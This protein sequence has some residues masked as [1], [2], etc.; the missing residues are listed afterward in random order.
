LLVKLGGCLLVLLSWFVGLASGAYGQAQVQQPRESPCGEEALRLLVCP[1]PTAP[2]GVVLFHL[3][4]T[5]G[6]EP[7][8]A[9]LSYDAPTDTDRLLIF[10]C[11]AGR[12]E[13]AFA[14]EAP[15]SERWDNLESFPSNG[16]VPGVVIWGGEDYGRTHL[17]IV[18]YTGSYTYLPSGKRV[19]NKGTFKVAFEGDEARLVDLDLDGIPEVVANMDSPTPEVWTLVPEKY[20]KVGTFQVDRLRPEY[21]RRRIEAVKKRLG[22]PTKHRGRV[23]YFGW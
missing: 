8:V 13:T 15:R 5:S 6:D 11:E 7:R 18:C 20:V 19:E 22:T 10:K 14:L 16:L 23:P 4:E 3:D 1:S 12:L 17:I 2:K 9:A 21:L